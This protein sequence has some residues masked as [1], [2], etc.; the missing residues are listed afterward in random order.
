MSVVSSAPWTCRGQLHD[1]LTGYYS[2]TVT[3]D[4][5]LNRTGNT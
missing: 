5:D 2:V 1:T 4:W 3:E